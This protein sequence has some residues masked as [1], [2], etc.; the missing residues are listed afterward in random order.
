MSGPAHVPAPPGGWRVPLVRPDVPAFAEV[1]AEIETA[2]AG[3]MLTKGPA[4]A[5]LETEAARFLGV[6]HVVGVG[7][8]TLGLAL[9]LDS[10]A[11]VRDRAAAAA[12]PAAATC[13][14]PAAARRPGPAG[15]ADVIV[16]SFIFLAAPAAIVWAKLRPVF[17]E[18]DPD[19]FTVD[20][21]AVAAAVT[22]RTAAILGCHTFGCP[23]DVAALERISAETGVPLVID[24]AHGLGTT[25]AGR[26]VGGGGLAQVFSLSPTKLVVAGEGGLVATDCDCL[27]DA[28]RTAREYGNDGAYGCS[29]PGLNARL[30]EISAIL[31]R[32][33][34]ARLDDV[35]GRRRAAAAAYREAL[36][37]V[38][39]LSF[40][41]IPAGAASSWKDF[42][43]GV[44]PVRFGCDRD[45]LRARLGER[46]IETR[47]YYSPAAHDM[48]AF[49]GFLRTG[50]RLPVTDR[51]AATLVALPMGV[52]VTP[53]VARAVA[54]EIRAA[55]VARVASG[56]HEPDA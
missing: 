34:L 41:R 40:Q 29:A 26:P 54:A 51:V 47:A 14:L 7:S 17:V 39:G 42:V 50:Q 3:G 44:D 55:A 11:A 1:T 48:E 18:I 12:C 16:P 2:V 45:T 22:P 52:H 27:A 38:P 25:V 23:C 5:R 31:A 37:D 8:C 28:V 15:A 43:V 6:R 19:T 21:A 49:R 56:A 35:A 9:V 10:L 13:P 24:A 20:P 46:G 53:D 33:S 30:P 32:A 36:A 4:L